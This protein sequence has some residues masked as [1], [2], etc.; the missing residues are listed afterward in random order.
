MRIV[1]L[2]TNTTHGHSLWLQ[3]TME[4]NSFVVEVQPKYIRDEVELHTCSNDDV[5]GG[6]TDQQALVHREEI[7]EDRSSGK[8][9]FCLF[10]GFINRPVF[11]G[12]LSLTYVQKV[13]SLFQRHVLEWKFCFDWCR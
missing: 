13:T 9:L 10:I 11:Q 2:K 12:C 7:P 1:C 8:W 3:V 4:D 6:V 5:T